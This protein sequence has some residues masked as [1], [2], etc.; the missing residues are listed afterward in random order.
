MSRWIRVYASH[1]GE[2][3]GDVE[4]RRPIDPASLPISD[5]LRLRL[6]KW[7]ERYW[8]DGLAD[9]RKGGET[10]IRD[11]GD[12]AAFSGEGR[13]IAKALKAELPGYA[14]N[15]YDAAA[16]ERNQEDDYP[17]DDHPDPWDYEIE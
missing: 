8:Y 2:G 12:L 4:R 1:D 3:L 9:R 15:Y 17:R 16:A 13:E 5:M 6:A 7:I 14:V 10:L 11:I